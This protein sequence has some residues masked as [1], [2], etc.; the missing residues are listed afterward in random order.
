MPYLNTMAPIWGCAHIK[1]SNAFICRTYY[2]SQKYQN[3]LYSHIR[4][5]WDI[6][7]NGPQP[8]VIR[9]VWA[10]CKALKIVRR[11]ARRRKESNVL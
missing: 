5:L 11:L 7:S 6:R 10:P 8:Q 1:T 2:D 4:M 9:S 3:A